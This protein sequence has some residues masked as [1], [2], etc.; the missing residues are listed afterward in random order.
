MKTK[1]TLPTE[2]NENKNHLIIFDCTKLFG[3]E[4]GDYCDFKMAKFKFEF[5]SDQSTVTLL[6][7]QVLTKF[8]SRINGAYR[9]KMS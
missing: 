8:N 1:L 5:N 7:D 2:V 4:F 9:F 3:E 6:L